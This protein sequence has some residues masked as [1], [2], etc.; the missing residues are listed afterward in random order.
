[1]Y[2]HF[3]FDDNDIENIRKV[4]NRFKSY[5]VKSKDYIIEKNNSNSI[6]RV[7]EINDN[8]NKLVIVEGRKP[9]NKN[10]MLMEYG[11]NNSQNMKENI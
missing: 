4:D 5:G 7:K 6:I 11:L 2:R 3:G 1:M 10:E 8:C 9:E